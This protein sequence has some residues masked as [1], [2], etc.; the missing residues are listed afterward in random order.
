MKFQVVS[1]SSCD[2]GRE[3]AEKL[4]NLIAKLEEQLAG[5]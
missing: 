5:M 2:L 1:D 3:R 4:A